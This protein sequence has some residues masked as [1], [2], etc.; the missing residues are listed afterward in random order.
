MDPRIKVFEQHKDLFTQKNILDIGCNDGSVTLEIASRFSITS[1][2]G[3]DIDKE[4]IGKAKKNHKYMFKK[5]L[6]P[7][8]L[9][10]SFEDGNYVL[11]DESLLETETPRFDTILCLSVTKWIH[12]NFGDDGI[13]MMFKRVFAQLR[14]GGAFVL[15]AQPYEGYRRRK[16]LTETTLKHFKSIKLFPKDFKSYLLSSEIGFTEYFVINESRSAKGFDRSIQVFVKE[17]DKN[18][19]E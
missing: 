19:E 6:N 2:T 7:N 3:I 16:R 13:K 14:P 8:L 1:I 10:V 18:M 9:S 5:S 17:V 15:E 12:L 4:L 11:L